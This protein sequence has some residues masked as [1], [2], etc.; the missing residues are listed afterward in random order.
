MLGCG[1]AAARNKS[2]QMAQQKSSESARFSGN[3]IKLLDTRLEGSHFL[4][5]RH[6]NSFCGSPEDVIRY[7]SLLG[8][9]LPMFINFAVAFP[10]V[11]GCGA[12]AAHNKS[13]HIAQKSDHGVDHWRREC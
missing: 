2:E 4:R 5:S 1:A 8:F 7:D 3:H 9:P 11:L 12:A 13:A 6:P 10:E